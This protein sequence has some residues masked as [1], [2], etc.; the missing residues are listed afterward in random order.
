MSTLA[1]NVQSTPV[2]TA[3]GARKTGGVTHGLKEAVRKTTIGIVDVAWGSFIGQHVRMRGARDIE[4]IMWQNA[5]EESAAFV[6]EHMFHVPMLRDKIKLMDASLDA[7]SARQGLYCE[8][9]VF[10]GDSLNYIAERVAGPVDGF[11]SFEGLPENWISKHPKGSLTAAGRLPKVR[12]NVRLFKGW[13]SDTL[14]GYLR[15]NTGPVAFIHID[16]DLY[17]S[18]KTVFSMMADRIGNGTVIL[19]DEYFNYPG[20]QKHEF[21]A[22]HEFIDERQLSFEYVGC[23]RDDSQVAVRIL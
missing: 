18:T 10:R 6:A 11:D 9:G 12:S 4:R 19:F 5:A 13:F 15:E 22:F 20:W 17:S 16:C 21:R 2:R 1:S 3:N 8:F 7:A 23:V 14:P